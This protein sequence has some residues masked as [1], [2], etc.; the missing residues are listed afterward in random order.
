MVPNYNWLFLRKQKRDGLK[1]HGV[2]FSTAELVR[3]TGSP[4]PGGKK[5]IQPLVR[6]D[7]LNL[8]STNL[9]QS[10]RVKRLSR[11]ALHRTLYAFLHNR[12]LRLRWLRSFTAAKTDR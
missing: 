2:E 10:R 11:I 4:P 9:L 5:N 7:V 1:G 6:L 3:Q 8:V 12:P